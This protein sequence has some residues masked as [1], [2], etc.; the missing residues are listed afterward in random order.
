M[1]TR[2]SLAADPLRFDG[3][4]EIG[5]SDK[6]IAILRK[7]KAQFIQHPAPAL[8]RATDPGVQL[9]SCETLTLVWIMSVRKTFQIVENF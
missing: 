3:L 5:F 9:A 4:P 1:R 6:V 8:D 2:P 7:A